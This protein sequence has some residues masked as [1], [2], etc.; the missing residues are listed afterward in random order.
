M[1]EDAESQRWSAWRFAWRLLEGI[2]RI[3][4][5]IALLVVL[6]WLLVLLLNGHSIDL[7]IR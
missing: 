6:I 7:V 1:P 2:A 4:W 3:T 5:N